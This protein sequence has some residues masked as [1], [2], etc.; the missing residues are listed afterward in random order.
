MNAIDNIKSAEAYPPLRNIAFPLTQLYLYLTAGC[1]LACRH[2]WLSPKLQTKDQSYPMLPLVLLTPI[3]N[4]AKALGLNRVKLTGGEPLMHPQIHE[5]LE[6]IRENDLSLTIETNGI[7]CS[8]PLAEAIASCRKAS[9]AISLDSADA[10]THEKIRGIKGCFIQAVTGILNLSN[11][12]LSPQIIMTVMRQNKDHI[13]PMIRLA[14]FLGASSIKFNILQPTGRGET[15]STGGESLTIEELLVMDDWI[16]NTLAPQ[17]PVKLFFSLPPAFRSLSQMY[18][19]NSDGCSR[20]GILNILGVLADGSYALCGIGAHTPD[21]VF[22][23]ALMDELETVWL[24][25]PILK[26]IRNGIP[27]RFK[28]ICGNCHMKRACAGSCIAQTYYRTG[29]LWE[30]FW[31]CKEAYKKGLFPSSRISYKKFSDTLI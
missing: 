2:C 4:E 20:C 17:T 1:N 18:G 19:N 28:G 14:E 11:A 12:G 31:I 27:H 10:D 5:I 7:L 30:P 6:I 21:L 9:I 15:I 8:P 16:S 25:H 24:H 23:T 13:E 3:L 26:E 29:S 22:G